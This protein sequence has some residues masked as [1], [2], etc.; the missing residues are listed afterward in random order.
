MMAC[1]CRQGGK[2]KDGKNWIANQNET[3]WRDGR[4]NQTDFGSLKC[5]VFHSGKFFVPRAVCVRLGA[6][7]E[8]AACFNP[9]TL[10]IEALW[11]GGFVRFSDVRYGFLHGVRPAGRMLPVP[12]RN[13]VSQPFEYQ[14][15]Y[16]HG[17]RTIFAYRIGGVEMLDAP[18]VEDGKFVREIAPADKHS[19]ARLTHGGKAQW[20][21]AI[22]TTGSLGTGRPYALDTIAPPFK[23]P[24]KALLYF[25]ASRRMES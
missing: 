5:G 25:S 2:A 3:V 24:W 12:E 23:N 7:G 22:R 19:L 13:Q 20:P 18:W 16:R 1:L 9:D 10:Q 15:F 8:M 6:D 11:E 21:Q 14:G 17:R 4:W